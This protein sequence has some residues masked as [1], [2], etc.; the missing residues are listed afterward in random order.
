MVRED[1]R[2][3]GSVKQ[4][5]RRGFFG[6]RPQEMTEEFTNDANPRDANPQS[7]C[8]VS[9]VLPT[10]ATADRENISTKKLLNTSFKEFESSQEV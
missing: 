10:N 3:K 9:D 4:R 1:K 2:K 7:S 8:G 5:K 6:K